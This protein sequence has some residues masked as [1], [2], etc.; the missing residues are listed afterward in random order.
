MRGVVTTDQDVYEA[1]APSLVR[2]ATALVG[3]SDAADVVSAVVVRV[4]SRRSLSSLEKPEAYLMQ[5]VMNEVRQLHR[6]RT[7]QRAAVVRVG[8]GPDA[9]DTADIARTDL[10][11]AVMALP[12]QQRAAAYLVYWCGYTAAE[13]AELMGWSD[14]TVRRYLHLVRNKLGRFTNE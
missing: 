1:V 13:A 6:G 2:F 3:P 10:T 4:L 8:P 11:D 5:A 7:R 12:P 14:G 9:R